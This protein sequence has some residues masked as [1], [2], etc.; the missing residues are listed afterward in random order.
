MLQI[1]FFNYK[2][3]K[4]KFLASAPGGVTRR[5]ELFPAE[6]EKVLYQMAGLFA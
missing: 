4:E 3:I 1:F 6:A 5:A 2:L